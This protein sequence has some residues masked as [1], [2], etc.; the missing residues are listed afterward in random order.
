MFVD[1]ISIMF[2]FFF[3]LKFKMYLFF[4]FFFQ[5]EDGIR[6]ATVT[7]VQTCALP[8]SSATAPVTMFLTYWPDRNSA[9]PVD[10]WTMPSLPASANPRTAAFSVS[11][12]VTLIA[13]YANPPAFARSS[14]S[15]YTSGVAIGMAIDPPGSVLARMSG[16]IPQP[17][18]S[19]PSEET[20]CR[21][22]KAHF[23]PLSADSLPPWR[24]PPAGWSHE[25]SC[26]RGYPVPRSGRGR[27]RAGPWRRGHHVH[28]RRLRR[29]ADRG[30]RA[31]RRPGGPGRPGR[32]ARAG[33]RPGGGHLR[34][35][36]VGGRR[37]GAAAV[38]QRRPL[39]VRVH[40]Q[41]LPAVAG[42][43]DPGRLGGPRLPAGG[44]AGAA[45]VDRRGAVRVPQGRLRTGRRVVLPEALHPGTGGAAGRPA[46]QQRPAHV[47]DRADR[48]RWPG[49]G[50][51]HPGRATVPCG[52]PRPGGVDARLG[53]ERARGPVQRHR[54]VGHDDVPRGL[55]GV[56]GGHRIGC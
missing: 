26:A 14:I 53:Y 9:P 3:Y 8:I 36:P 34:V 45:G 16:S 2:I 55:R 12:D 35:H 30:D 15:A 39:R 21:A 25:G 47:V 44:V 11:D 46:R 41:R 23:C 13:G 20:G 51:G 33:V 19:A 29:A 27:R 52:R 37:G 17:P 54:A 4:F 7:G 50:A 18:G 24:G 10:T 56:P 5:A 42:P 40:H 32:A 31:A 6:Y 49:T 43:A 1:I 48:A 38:G 22:D 28:P